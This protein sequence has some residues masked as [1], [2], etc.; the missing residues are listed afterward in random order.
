[1]SCNRVNIATNLS[2]GF[3]PPNWRGPHSKG[4]HPPC[5]AKFRDVETF[6]SAVG[7]SHLPWSNEMKFKVAVILLGG[8]IGAALPCWATQGSVT[9]WGGGQI[10]SPTTLTNIASISVGHDHSLA[11]G[12]DGTVTAW[13]YDFDGQSDVPVDLGP[14]KAI[15]AGTFFSAALKTDGT[16]R[17]WGDGQFGQLQ[18][19]ADATNIVAI[20][21]GRAHVL[22]IKSNGTVEAW[23][24]VWH[25]GMTAP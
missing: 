3:R 21:A 11:L 15:A 5:L 24:S 17:A 10:P 13:G 23:G 20:S 8:L 9:S 7:K 12:S 2:M 25:S 4:F 16:V 22:A 19:P 18:A 14:V 6:H 1:M